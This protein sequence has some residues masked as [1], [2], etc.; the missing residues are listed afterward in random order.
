[1][2]VKIHTAKSENVQLL[3]QGVPTLKINLYSTY[4]IQ[5]GLAIS[6]T[7]IKALNV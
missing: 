6:N 4:C 2:I 7:L 5:I 1:M 3:P